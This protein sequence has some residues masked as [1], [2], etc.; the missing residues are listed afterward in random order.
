MIS[1]NLAA[2][3]RLTFWLFFLPLSTCST[4]TFVDAIDS[5]ILT[6]FKAGQSVSK[7][8]ATRLCTRQVQ[9]SPLISLMAKNEIIDA[10][11]GVVVVSFHPQSHV[12]LSN[13][14]WQQC[15]L[16]SNAKQTWKIQ[17]TLHRR[18]YYYMTQRE[19]SLL[20]LNTWKT[21]L[22]ITIV[23]KTRKQMLKLTRSSTHWQKLVLLY[24]KF[25]K[26][27]LFKKNYFTVW[28]VENTKCPTT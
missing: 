14:I 20:S 16:H 10:L 27:S 17:N 11:I 18:K 1:V 5:N 22:P 8:E 3:S 9:A 2:A 23:L 26:I 15:I 21:Q 7:I 6:Q 19:R 13:S 25:T 12:N 28:I 24:P 4:A